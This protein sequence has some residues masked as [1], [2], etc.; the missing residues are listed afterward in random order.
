M[1][2]KIFNQIYSGNIWNDPFSRSGTGSNLVQ[3]QKIRIAVPAIIEK[4]GVKSFLDIP[5]GDF[6]WMKEIHPMLSKTLNSYIGGDIVEDLIKINTKQFSDTKFRFDLLDIQSSPLPTADLLFC[7]DC[8]V[9]FSY[10]DIL[11]AINNIKKSQCK[12]ML[13][14]TFPGRKNR[15]IITGAWFPIDLQKFPFYFPEPVEII[16]EDCTE[17]N[18]AYIDKSIALWE[19][20]RISITKFK[21]ALLILSVIHK[22]ILITGSWKKQALQ[23]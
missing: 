11:K 5:C 19:I 20:K 16:E 21:I 3:T 15:N 1:M 4:Y 14:T 22:L 17:Y 2:E 13:T 18:H 9:H 23:R 12:Y 6:F 8:F 7:R 10:K